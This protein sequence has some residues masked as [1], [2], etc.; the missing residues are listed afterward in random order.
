M[1]FTYEEDLSDDLS[2][3]RFHVGDTAS[4]N[5]LFSDAEVNASLAARNGD[6]LATAA[7]LCEQLATRFARDVDVVADGQSLKRSQRSAA[8]AARAGAL[9][10]KSGTGGL[11]TIQVTRVDG[12]SDDVPGRQGSRSG[13]V[14]PFTCDE[15]V[16]F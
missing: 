6:V 10:S 8:Y 11:S 14:P 5:P 13:Q 9:R 3:V 4:A 15:D 7:D 12:V 16:S 1:A 2:Q